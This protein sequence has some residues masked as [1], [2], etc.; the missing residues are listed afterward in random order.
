MS[1]QYSVTCTEPDC[2]ATHFSK[3]FCRK[4]HSRFMRHGDAQKAL[5]VLSPRGAPR[6]W[7]VAHA[8]YSSDEC[9]KWPFSRFPD[10]RAHM[11][12]G[13][14]TRIMCEMTKG[15]PPSSKHQAAHSC[16]RGHEACVN[17]RHLRWATPVEN[18][19]DKELHGSLIRGARHYAARLSEPQIYEIRAMAKWASLTDVSRHFGIGM[20]HAHK[21]IHKISWSHI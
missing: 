9:L 14:P 1:K 6:A 17:P 11:S 8:G 10:G 13:K 7:L 15:P 18:S 21:I 12:G 16:G 5:K 4:H 19:A 20:S 3:G 2:E